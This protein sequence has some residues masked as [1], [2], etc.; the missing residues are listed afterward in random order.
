MMTGV[1]QLAICAHPADG[2][3]A[4]NLSAYLALN[5]DA[6]PD[7]ILLSGEFD[8]FEAMEAGREAGR[9]IVV[10]SPHSV[11]AAGHIERWTAASRATKAWVLADE[12]HYPKILE[13]QSFFRKAGSE[14]SLLRDVL[15]W[16]AT[17]IAKR[18]HDTMDEQCLAALVDRPGSAAVSRATAGALE[19][20][21]RVV[22]NL[23]ARS[24]S[25]TSLAS[26]ACHAMGLDRSADREALLDAVRSACASRRQLIVLQG[27]NPGVFSPHGRSSIATIEDEAAP[28]IAEAAEMTAILKACEKGRREA[29]ADA[30]LDRSLSRAF[31]TADWPL[32]RELAWAAYAYLKSRYRLAEAFDLMESLREAA[33]HHGEVDTLDACVF[34]K[35]WIGERWSA[36]ASAEDPPEGPQ[37]TFS[38]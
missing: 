15:R 20:Y 31:A 29:P 7:V 34:E 1:L 35:R 10:L 19:E 11:P 3:L 36:A 25:V 5:A 21:F 22:V 2:G 23:D 24:R 6:Q 33:L 12:C 4:T 37:F 38:W 9:T 8:I 27:A 14:I 30:N 17:G 16:V 18:A 26:E 28:E 32:I 13:R